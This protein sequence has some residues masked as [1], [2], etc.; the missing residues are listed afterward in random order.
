MPDRPRRVDPAIEARK[1]AAGRLGFILGCL[2]AVLGFS[3][4]AYRAP[5]PFG[6][7]SALTLFLI[8]ALNIPLGIGLALLA[9]RMTRP[10]GND[11]QRGGKRN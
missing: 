2:V 10:R 7:V 5:R 4:N 11:R 8:A 1:F 3:V 6:W 9:E